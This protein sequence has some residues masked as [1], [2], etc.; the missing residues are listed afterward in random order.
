MAKHTLTMDIHIVFQLCAVVW[1]DVTQFTSCFDEQMKAHVLKVNTTITK[2]L[3][4][5]RNQVPLIV[6][7]MVYVE[8]ALGVQVDW[9]TILGSQ[10]TNMPLY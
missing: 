3:I 8:V 2:N 5:A 6:A 1:N 10:G 4:F 9:R 7:Q